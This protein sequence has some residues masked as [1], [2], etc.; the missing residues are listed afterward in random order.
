MKLQHFYLFH[1]SDEDEEGDEDEP[2][3]S[4]DD[5]IRTVAEKSNV[6]TFFCEYLLVYVI[7]HTRISKKCVIADTSYNKT[8]ISFYN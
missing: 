7:M 8:F 2:E 4:S 5:L 6:V 3:M 1:F